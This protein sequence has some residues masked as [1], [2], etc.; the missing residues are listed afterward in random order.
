[1]SILS[2]HDQRQETDIFGSFL[3]EYTIEKDKNRLPTSDLYFRYTC[4][5]KDNGYRQMNSKNFVRELRR[6]CD[7]RRN[8]ATG[9]VVAGLALSF[10]PN[11]FPE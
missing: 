2:Y 9:N 3:S 1:V 4:W 11:P 6:R 10:D 7:V 8:G 5:A